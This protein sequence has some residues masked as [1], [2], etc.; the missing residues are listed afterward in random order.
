ML[1]IPSNVQG[2]PGLDNGV[3]W[4]WLGGSLSASANAVEIKEPKL[5]IS[6]TA[7]PLI[8]AIGSTITFTVS[9]AHTPDSALDAFDVVVT[10]DLP[11]GLT[12]IPG[13]ISF[14]GLP[15][16]ITDFD[17]ATGVLTFTWHTFPLSAS[18]V[19]TFQ[20]TFV[21][22]APVT[23]AANVAWTSLP[24]DPQ[25]Q[26]SGPPVLLST[27]NDFATERWY[28]PT[29][30]TG[31]NDYGVSASV[32]VNAPS[33]GKWLPKT[34]FA[35]D[36]ITEL[37]PMPADFAYAQTDVWIEIPKLDQKLTLVGV[38]FNNETGEWDLRW[39]GSEAGW[40]EY[41]A[42]PTYSGNSAITAHATLPTGE[43]GPFAQLDSLSYGDQIIVHINGQ[44]YIYEVRAKLQVLPEAVRSVL[45]HE[46]ISWLTLIT[47]KSYN[48]RTGEYKYRSVVRAVLLT[49][50][51]E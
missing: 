21:G 8:A 19:I 49:V 24:I 22:P 38:P 46:E 37:P 29:D 34:G 7:D 31:V 51:D 17:T 16:D 3:T 43:D 32:V 30:L 40:L 44:R 28:D 39:L 48:E 47:C 13:T 41:T 14:T 10:D 27:F 11:E 6:K 12:L 26:P 45:K 50:E 36:V 25:P 2:T 9:I 35:P 15:A 5:S 20:T 42:F 1:D 33:G 18:S 23:N 4:S